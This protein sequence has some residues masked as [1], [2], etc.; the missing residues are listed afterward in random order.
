MYTEVY[1]LVM[2]DAQTEMKAPTPDLILAAARALAMV[3]DGAHERDGHGYN[4]V[5]SPVAKS[6]LRSPKPTVRQIRCLWSMLRKYKGQLEANGFEYELMV[7][8]PLPAEAPRVPGRPAEPYVP[9]PIQVS[10]SWA[11][12]KYGRRISIITSTYSADVVLR[13]KKLPKRWFDKEGEISGIRNIWLIPDEAGAFDTLIRSLAE[14][15]PPVKIDVAADLKAAME[16]ARSKKEKAYQASRAEDA[17]LE[18]PTKLPL[19]PFQ[20]AGVK[21]AIDHNGRVLIADDMGLGKTPEALGFLCAKGKDALPALV[22]CPATLR[23][24]WALE[25][26][27]F[28]GFNYQIL[29]AKSSLNQLRKAGFVANV[30]PEPG[31]DVTIMNYDILEAETATTWIRMLHKSGDLEE[32]THAHKNLVLAG[33]PAVK[34][35][36]KAMMKR[37]GLEIE[38]RLARVKT[39]IEKLGDAVRKKGKHICSAVAGIPTEEFLKYGWKTM[40]MDEVHGIKESS[41]QRGMAADELSRGVQYVLGLTGTPIV[42]RPKEAWH[43][44]HCVDPMVFPS[45]FDYGRRYCNGHETRFGWDFSGASN[46]EELDYKL[47]T[48]VMIRRMKEQV[49][50]ELPPLNRITVPMMLDKIGEYEDESKDPIKK[51]ALLKKEREEWKAVLTTLSDE[52]RKRYITE[53]A[54]QASRAHRVS[55]LIFEGLEKV[56]QAAVRAKFQ[57]CVKFIL[58]LQEAQG[59]IIVFMS[60]HEFIDRMA[61]EMGKADL[62]V[63]VIDGRVPMGKRDAVKD[64]FQNGD[65]QILVAGI[66]AASEGLTLTASHTVVFVELDWNPSRHQQA[67][68]RAHR[69]GQTAVT[70]VYYLVGLGTVEES[71]ARLID[72]KAE[73]TAA[74]TG[75]TDQTMSE[76]SIMEAVLEELLHE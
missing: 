7:P 13:I 56:K 3:C 72:T 28:T 68:A 75:S 70:T 32:L 22:V 38:N 48:T 6:I 71:I 4:G 36:V 11:Q 9:A 17:E 50:K 65:T 55:G 69:F 67:Q 33:I 26:G 47:R 63:G 42:N 24:N 51:L 45:F 10:F 12:T 59:K 44:V 29:T 66:R 58:E 73:V 5:D 8:P 14:I 39:E 64:A 23:G 54:E 46:L 15:V 53:H 41:S 16:D 21:W 52:E 76:Q 40:I 1:P 18:I 30:K 34:H 2:N 35:V 31:Y 20:K 27:K 74:A 19:R 62:K 61:E 49:L 37:P 43:Q 57:E 60:H 25:V